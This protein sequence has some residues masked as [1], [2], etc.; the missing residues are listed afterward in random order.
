[1]LAIWLLSLLSA[2][3]TT[4]VIAGEIRLARLEQ[5]PIPY[6]IHLLIMWTLTLISWAFVF[7]AWHPWRI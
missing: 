3:L 6:A 5:V 7:V 1:M 4:Y 2:G